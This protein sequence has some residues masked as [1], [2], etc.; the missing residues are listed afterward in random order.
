MHT[1]EMDLERRA[2]WAVGE[3]QQEAEAQ[4]GGG[5]RDT[6]AG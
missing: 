4:G 3:G 5:P 2:G 6:D 1:P